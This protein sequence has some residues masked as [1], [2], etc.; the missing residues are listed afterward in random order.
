MLLLEL[1][2]RLVVLDDTHRENEMYCNAVSGTRL[3][4]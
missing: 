3:N 4:T 2:Q 1:K